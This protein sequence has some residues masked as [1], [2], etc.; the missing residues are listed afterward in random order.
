MIGPFA[1]MASAFPVAGAHASWTWRLARAGVRGER[2][3]SWFMNGF[4][5]AGHLGKLLT[6]LYHAVRGCTQTYITLANVP[7]DQDKNPFNP[8]AKLEMEWW[9]PVFQIILVSVVAIILLTRLSRRSS[10]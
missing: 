2:Q 7:T 5:L 8:P 1:E 6:G 9:N 3:W 10:F 4:V